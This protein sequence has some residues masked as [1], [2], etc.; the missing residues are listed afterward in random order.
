[1]LVKSPLYWCTSDKSS[2]SQKRGGQMTSGEE[3][4]IYIAFYS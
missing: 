3:S 1:M 4:L 2:L